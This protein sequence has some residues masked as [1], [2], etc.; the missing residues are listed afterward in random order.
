[1]H[2][3]CC[4]IIKHVRMKK[5]TWKIDPSHSDIGFRVKHLMIT[6]VSGHFQEYELEVETEGEDFTRFSKL[7]FKADIS[8]ITT[9]NEQRD[10]HLKTSDFFSAEEYREL[11][12]VG[13]KLLPSGDHYQLE[14][15]LT[16]RGITRPITLD[17][18]FGGIVTDPYGETKAGF[19]VEGKLK[20]K[21]FKLAWDAVTE[22][23]QVV[24]SNEVR[25][26]CEVEL[27]KQAV[28]ANAS[29]VAEKA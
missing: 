16:I 4:Q 7:I 27:V 10:T 28:P 20:R 17:V 22:A 8:S 23:G 14:G 2:A 6:T 15:D 5:T 9:N 29:R 1:M 12:F 25:I 3:F 24:V 21:D 18:E 26:N 11:T 19:T 13:K